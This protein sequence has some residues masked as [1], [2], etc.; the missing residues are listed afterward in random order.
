MSRPA[1]DSAR[2]LDAVAV[3]PPYRS[4]EGSYHSRTRKDMRMWANATSLVLDRWLQLISS[5]CVRERCEVG[6]Q[7]H[8]VLPHR[9]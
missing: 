3:G 5:E 2:H 7:L 1:D 8:T 9:Q 4:S 6:R